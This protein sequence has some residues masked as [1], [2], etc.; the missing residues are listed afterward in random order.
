MIMYR[1]SLGLVA[2]AVLVLMSAGAGSA[3][4]ASAVT[5]P[6]GSIPAGVYL[7]LKIA[8][9]CT[10]DAGSAGSVTVEGNLT[11]LSGG[12]LVA[13]YGG[14]AGSPAPS[15]LIV[16]GNLD[17]ESGA[18]LNLGC[19]PNYYQCPNDPSGESVIKESVSGGGSYFTND[20]I[21]GNLTAESALAVVVHHTA[22]GGNV[23]MTAGGGGVY[24]CTEGLPQLGDSPPYGDFEDDVIG[25]SL[26]I[27][28]VQTCW[29]GWFRDTV[30]GSVNFSA[31]LTGEPDG[32]EMGNNVVL[33]SL[34]CG[35]NSPLP[36]I[37][38]SGAAPS[39]VLL[40]TAGQCANQPGLVVQ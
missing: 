4:A 8:G 1:N 28:G 2:G 37:G 6:G 18:I 24:S 33:G 17:M 13:V 35:G 11:I 31:N 29:L 32:N 36:Q 38:D 19:E 7:S 5:C 40:V 34:A 39:T 26:S 21:G 3:S 23:Y 14:I 15:N 25:G 22:I 30:I 12:S 27:L 10:I 20:V 9:A 16:G